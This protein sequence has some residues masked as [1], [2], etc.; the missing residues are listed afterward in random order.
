[1]HV[2]SGDMFPKVQS[3]FMWQL[4]NDITVYLRQTITCL[5]E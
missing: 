1:M 4:H 3:Y 2:R 5:S